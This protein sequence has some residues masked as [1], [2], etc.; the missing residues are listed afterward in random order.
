MCG[1]RAGRAD[2]KDK[3][4][5]CTLIQRYIKEKPKRTPICKECRTAVV[6]G[7]IAGIAAALSAARAGA[8]VVLLEQEYMLGGLA[9]M[10]LITHYLPLCDGFGHQVSFGIAE[11]L[12][13]ASASLDESPEP[14]AVWRA[15]IADGRAETAPRLVY[16]FNPQLFAILAE[17]LLRKAGV[18]ILY[19]T[20]VCGVE[21]S[22]RKI[23]ALLIESREGR[24]A[25]KAENVIDCSGDAA[26]CYRS[27][28]KTEM[29]RQ[30]NLLAAWYA[31]TQN[32]VYRVN[33]LGAADIPDEYKTQQQRLED[34]RNH[35]RYLGVTAEELSAFMIA[36]H[37]M[38]LADYLKKNNS[39]RQHVLATIPTIPEVRMTRKIVGLTTLEENENAVFND[40]IGLISNWKR[41]GPIY[42]IP[43][44]SLRVRE[45]DNLLVAGRC[46]SVSDT[47]W[48]VTRVI[49]ACAVT[50]EAAGVAAAMCHDFS[51]L[52]ILALQTAL[53]VRGVALHRS[54]VTKDTVR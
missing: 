6:G 40:S 33:T 44:S 41:R 28:V 39:S 9:T 26:V 16:E 11:E 34:R 30:R 46:I 48:D 32:G 54:E 36:S 23:R 51:K 5:E 2:G 45:F 3:K 1:H 14:F 47:M 43:F 24:W 29:F 35:K 7:G 38:L 12:M 18:R 27:G 4:G 22:D 25:I 20:G 17:Q 8:D 10:G 37:E 19:G 42:E 53:R 50:G 31:A 15:A 49:P 52:P 21:V 13:R